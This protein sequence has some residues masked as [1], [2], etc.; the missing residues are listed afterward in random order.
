LFPKRIFYGWWITASAFTVLFINAGTGVYAYSLYVKPLQTEFGWSRGEIMLGFAIWSMASGLAAPFV[1]RFVDRYGP[2][3]SVLAGGIAAGVACV[4][5]G[6]VSSLM[7]YYAAYALLGLSTCATGSIPL[8]SMIS[9]WFVAKRG[10]ALGIM[11]AGIGAGGLLFAPLL[12]GWLIPDVGWRQAFITVGVLAVVFLVPVALLVI[13]TSPSDKGLQ[14]Y[15]GTLL[16]AVPQA[17]KPLSWKAGLAGVVRLRSFWLIACSYF[18]GAYSQLGLLQ[19]Q[20]PYL[21]DTGFPAVVAAGALGAVGLFSTLAKLG[22]GELCDRIPAKIVWAGSL[23]LMAVGAATLMVI[24]PGSPV[25]LLWIYAVMTGLGMGGWLPTMSLMVSTSF[26][27]SAY[28]SIFGVIALTFAAGQAAGPAI[29]GLLVDV[30]RSY[31]PVF[32]MLIAGFLIA[33]VTAM[34]VRPKPAG[35]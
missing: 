7:L 25:W 34:I 32:L 24:S 12:G 22:A 5:L 14:P 33:G 9:N 16:S 8:S 17:K 30:T 2:G 31:S 13:R 21:D 29:G 20:V 15:G 23:A 19:S 3:R 4:L 6:S 27:L 28:A 18:F 35:K 26:G 10:M 1:G 11:S